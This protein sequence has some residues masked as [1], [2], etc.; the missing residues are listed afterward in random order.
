[1][2]KLSPSNQDYL[3]AILRLAKDKN[4]IR[5][6]DIAQ[7]MSVSRASVNKAIGVLKSLGYVKQ[8]RYCPIILT[9]KGIRAALAVRERHDTL[10][11]FLTNVLNVSYVSAEEDACKMEHSISAETFEKLKLFLNK[12]IK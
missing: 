3:E 11:Y 9:E 1:M 4:E 6:V 12:T 5:S 10:K 2:N 8:E 7:I